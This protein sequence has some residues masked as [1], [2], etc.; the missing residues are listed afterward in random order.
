MVA[1]VVVR[2][3]VAEVTVDEAIVTISVEEVG[4]ADGTSNGTEGAN[5]ASVITSG[6]NGQSPVALNP[7]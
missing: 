4:G 7:L 1:V 5:A 6:L 2:G 3:T